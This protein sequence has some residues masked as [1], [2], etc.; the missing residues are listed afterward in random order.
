MVFIR[1]SDLMAH[2]LEHEKNEDKI[3]VCDWPGCDYRSVNFSQLKDHKG[4]HIKIQYQCNWPD[5]GQEF[6]QEIEL[7]DHLSIHTSEKQFK[8]KWPRCGQQFNHQQNFKN[9]MRNHIGEKKLMQLDR[10][11]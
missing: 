8:Y 2:Q 9:H 6:R 5:C 4:S 11:Q 10:L 1:N 3:F 7:N